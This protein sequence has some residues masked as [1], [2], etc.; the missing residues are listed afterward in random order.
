MAIVRRS[1][2]RGRVEKETEDGGEVVKVTLPTKMVKA[3]GTLDDF[4]FLIHGT[5]KI[6]KTSLALQTEDPDDKVLFLQFDPPQVSYDR[7]ELLIPN[8][9]TMKKAVKKLEIAAEKGEFPYAR[10]VVDRVD[11]S[12]S[13]TERWVKEKLGIDKMSEE[14]F[15]G[16]WMKLSEE[17]TDLMDRILA[18]PC[19]KW[20]LCHSV[21]EEEE[22]RHGDVVK[23]LKPNLNRRADDALNGKVDGWFAYT[24][25][26]K[27]R[28]LV[29]QGDENMGAGH[30]INGKFLTP[31]GERVRA[32][33]M[34]KNEKEAFRNF[35]AAFNNEQETPE[36]VYKRKKIRVKTGK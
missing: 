29:I 2:R 8:W 27:H 32:I 5:K 14:A 18:L 17:F 13:K 11:V 25:D 36:P 30:R 23:I 22:N 28:T 19:G 20:F 16:A 1:Q 24:Y 9:R 4:S 3:S 31:E 35:V 15:G 7:L 26:G 6:G 10:I 12:F 33:P 21:I 34:G